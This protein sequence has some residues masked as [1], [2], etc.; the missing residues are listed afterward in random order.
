MESNI[1]L[2]N[3]DTIRRAMLGNPQ[4]SKALAKGFKAPLGSTD[5]KKAQ[6]I[7][8]VFSKINPKKDYS[9]QGGVYYDGKG[10][11]MDSIKGLFSSSPLVYNKTPKPTP[12]SGGFSPDSMSMFLTPPGSQPSPIQGPLTKEQAAGRTILPAAPEIKAKAKVPLFGVGDP[13]YGIMK[14]APKTDYELPLIPSYKAKEGFQEAP[15]TKLVQNA[16]AGIGNT[17]IKEAVNPAINTVATVGGYLKNL[18]SK[19]IGGVGE[20]AG[21]VKDMFVEQ[22]KMI[23]QK[24]DKMAGI[25]SPTAEVKPKDSSKESVVKNADGST[26]KKIMK[27]NA[28]GTTSTETTVTKADGSSE[29]IVT[30]DPVTETKGTDKKVEKVDENAP[31]VGSGSSLLKSGQS[32]GTPTTGGTSVGNVQGDTTQKSNVLGSDVDASGKP[33]GASAEMLSQLFAGTPIEDLPIGKN[34]EEQL[35]KL[36]D[37]V[38]KEHRVDEIYKQLTDL[39]EQSPNIKIEMGDYIRNR[40]Q[41]V[42]SIDKML[43]EAYSI[44]ASGGLTPEAKARQKTYINMLEG[45]RANHNQS[46]AKFLNRGIEQF[47]NEVS[48]VQS[49]YKDAVANANKD[50]ER[51]GTLLQS[52]YERRMAEYQELKDAAYNAKKRKYEMT[53]WDYEIAEMNGSSLN[54]GINALKAGEANTAR[55]KISK[56][57]ELS[58]G[59]D[60]NEIASNAEL[61]KTLI[62]IVEEEGEPELPALQTIGLSTINRLKALGADDGIKELNQKWVQQIVNTLTSEYGSVPAIRQNMKQLGAFIVE[63]YTPEIAG[64]VNSNIEKYKETF[65]HLAPKERWLLR[66][67]P[68]LSREEFINIDKNLNPYLL[69]SIYDSY[70]RQNEEAGKVIDPNDF[71]NL[72]LGKGDETDYGGESALAN[73]IVGNFKKGIL[74]RINAQ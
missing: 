35:I 4:I 17:V 50:F 56:D 28:D 9:G 64:H 55:T 63:N 70:Q 59:E 11:I 72:I 41:A 19:V 31:V 44:Y 18:A 13:S 10:G 26:T 49:L 57:W 34:P 67:K 43:D 62:R 40:D 16:A 24:E 1:E 27:E 61:L 6:S 74:S 23:Y 58:Q 33:V 32:S 66:D 20:T 25:K 5:R 14:M 71:V 48:R 12:S 39:Q 65:K 42:S 8:S 36:Q 22:P 47:N 30:K 15:A 73:K 51:K 68:A 38:E 69:A 54:R 52:D 45:M 3:K 53:K 29:K 37:L 60:K 46:Y 2:K 21:M 7:I